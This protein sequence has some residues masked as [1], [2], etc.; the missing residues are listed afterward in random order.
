MNQLG[1]RE[2][3]ALLSSRSLRLPNPE[4]DDAENL[5]GWNV[6]DGDII[7]WR[8]EDDQ[9]VLPR[10]FASRFLAG[11]NGMGHYVDIDDRRVRTERKLL[12]DVSLLKPL[13]EHQERASRAM[14]N[15]QQGQYQAPTGSG[16][17]VTLLDAWAKSGMRGHILTDRSEIMEQW[18]DRC[19]EFLGF[20]PGMIGDGE[21]DERELTI[22]M[23]QTLWAR[24]EELQADGFFRR[25][26]FAKLDECHHAS[27]FTY[28]SIMEMYPSFYRGGVSATPDK[29]NGY[30]TIILALLGEVYHITD[31]EELFRKGLL[32][33]PKV[34]L[35]Y[36]DYRY[37]GKLSWRSPSAW[38]KLCSDLAQDEERAELVGK[39]MLKEPYRAHLCL[40]GRLA[41]LNL[42][43]D[44][45]VDMGWPKAKTFM[46][47]GNEDRIER[48][49]AQKMADGG[50]CVIFSTIADEAFDV[51]RLDRLHLAFP[52]R[53]T[54]TYKQRVG[55]IMRTHPR[56]TD[57]LVYDYVDPLVQ[58][59]R[60]QAQHRIAEVYNALNLE[61]QT[62]PRR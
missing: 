13:R 41:H 19:E 25:P 37:A 34:K 42:L 14:L 54:G 31:I 50:A 8:V 24:R 5:L 12:K 49:H 47:T 27:A 6:V 62:V 35:V 51:P 3:D 58:T 36:T 33:R 18:V 57:A 56:K 60:N 11:M 15:V 44:V 61:V 32:I 40:S 28:H 16:K 20:R 1:S 38:A 39:V 22:C 43:R 55:R 45:V 53:Q 17:T 46:L 9:L 4:G 10:G 29:D 21:F 59:L 7:L 23:V 52:G 26:G 30:F 2:R 48:K